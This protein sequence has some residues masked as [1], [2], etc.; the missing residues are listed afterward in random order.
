MDGAMDQPRNLKG[1]GFK[2]GPIGP[3]WANLYWPEFTKGQSQVQASMPNLAGPWTP[4]SCIIKKPKQHSWEK[5]RYGAPGH[6]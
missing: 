2:F 1:L 3:G 5:V 4:Y 6:L